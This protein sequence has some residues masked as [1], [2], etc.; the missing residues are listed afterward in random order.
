MLQRFCL[1]GFIVLA[2]ALTGNDQKA[3]FQADGQVDFKGH[4]GAQSAEVTYKGDYATTDQEDPPTDASTD[5]PTEIPTNTPT[6]APTEPATESTTVAGTETATNASLSGGEVA[7]SVAAGDQSATSDT[8]TATSTNSTAPTIATTLV[9]S[10]ANSIA[11]A[12]YLML[13]GSFFFYLLMFY[14]TS[15]GH[16]SIERATWNV[17]S[18]AIALGCT[19][20]LYQAFKL[21]WFLALGDGDISF[22]TQNVQ[23]G[24]RF[25]LLM[26]IFPFVQTLFRGR[27]VPL[28]VLSSLGGNV[29][30]FAAIEIMGGLLSLPPWNSSPLFYFCGIQIAVVAMVTLMIIMHFVVKGAFGPG[31]QE[32]TEEYLTFKEACENAENTGLALSIGFLISMLGRFVVQGEMPALGGLPTV[33]PANQITMLLG[34][35]G[36]SIVITCIISVAFR[37]LK[38][39]NSPRIPPRLRSPLAARITKTFKLVWL[40]GSAWLVF[41]Y[42]QWAFWW[43][44]PGGG[45]TTTMAN[46]IIASMLTCIVATTGSF[47]SIVVLCLLFDILGRRKDAALRDM[48]ST[49][50]LVLG[51]SWE[52]AFYVTIRGVGL[53][54]DNPRQGMGAVI[55][56]MCMACVMILPVW[57]WLI[58]PKALGIK[59]AEADESLLSESYWEG[60][61]EPVEAGTAF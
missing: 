59:D 6:G 58:V 20:M 53:E 8:Q 17:V 9:G 47:G 13:A 12:A 37:F 60:E 18:G 24:I 3:M 2:G 31:Q 30:G 7:G 50:S 46:E 15:T 48:T 25:L 41:Y 35:A 27:V 51:F 16:E 29:I 57:G 54:Y 52:S 56:L 38:H 40:L 23:A 4:D 11:T 5:A 21:T 10:M 39:S 33:R 34:M 43:S 49:F 26:V 22:M 14:M 42:V 32:P 19:T 45:A 1:A 36:A 28:A 61:A 55:G 44:N